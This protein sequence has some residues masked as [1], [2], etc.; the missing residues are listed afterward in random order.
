MNAKKQEGEKFYWL[1]VENRFNVTTVLDM[2][3]KGLKADDK[4]QCDFVDGYRESMMIDRMGNN[5][6]GKY[7]K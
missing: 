1:T 5:E 6:G 4:D 2:L 3:L 7:E